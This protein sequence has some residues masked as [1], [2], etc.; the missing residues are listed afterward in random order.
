MDALI[1]SAR[2]NRLAGMTVALCVWP[3]GFLGCALKNTSFQ[4]LRQLNENAVEVIQIRSQ[5]YFRV[6]CPYRR[7][8]NEELE[9]LRRFCAGE[10]IDFSDPFDQEGGVVAE[11]NRSHHADRALL[12]RIARLIRVNVSQSASIDASNR[13]GSDAVAQVQVQ[14]LADGDLRVST[15]Y[16]CLADVFRVDLGSREEHRFVSTD[17]A[18]A[19]R[20]LARSHSFRTWAGSDPEYFPDYFRSE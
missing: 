3:V 5:F 14:S 19:L 6:D 8:D 11:L 1:F 13:Y 12:T 10:P 16:W 2:W 15:L 9:L 20:E 18:R 17:L 4:E 7:L